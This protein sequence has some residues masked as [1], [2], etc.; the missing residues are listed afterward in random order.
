MNDKSRRPNSRIEKVETFLPEFCRVDNLNGFP[1]HLSVRFNMQILDRIIGREE[2]GL[3]LLFPRPSPTVCVVLLH[4]YIPRCLVPLPF[5]SVLIVDE[6][7]DDVY[8]GASF[9]RDIS[10]VVRHTS[11]CGH[12]DREQSTLQASLFSHFLY[13]GIFQCFAIL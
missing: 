4:C 10:G 5:G 8:L 3:K 1:E 6:R 12:R 11:S 13:S 2:L 7:L 9:V